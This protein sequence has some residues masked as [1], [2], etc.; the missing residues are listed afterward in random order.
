MNEHERARTLAMIEG[1]ISGDFEQ[2]LEADPG[3]DDYTCIAAKLNELASSL[4][5]RR[6]HPG[7]AAESSEIGYREIFDSATDMIFVQDAATGEFIDVN[8]ETV[9]ATGYTLAEFQQHGVQLFSPQSVE[10]S[11]DVAM[12]HIGKA[13][14][15]VPQLFEWAYVD[16]SG[17]IHPTEVHLKRMLFDGRAC[18]L[19]ITR[20]IT[21]R[22]KRESERLELDKK[23]LQGQKLESL[24]LLAGG[25]AHDFNN[26]LMGIMGHAG[27]AL[28]QLPEDTDA[29]A[30]VEKLETAADRATELMRQL[31]LFSGGGPVELVPVDLSELVEEITKLL[32]TVVSKRA[33]LTFDLD[34]ALPRVKGNPTA[35]RQIA[36]N[37]LTNASEA[38]GGDVGTIALKTGVTELGAEDLANTYVDWERPA[39][40]YSFLE[41]ADTGCGM[42]A[43]TISRLFDPFYSNK[44]FGRGL[45]LASVLGIVR[46]MKG[47]IDVQSA[48]GSGTRFTVFFPC[49]E[50]QPTASP[51]LTGEDATCTI[52]G[53]VL[54]VDDDEIA[55]DTSRAYL[56]ALGINS[57]TANSGEEGLQQLE[58]QGDSVKAVLLD[59]TMPGLSGLETLAEMRTNDWRQPVI[60]CS[61]YMLDE[62]ADFEIPRPDAY[63][64][65]PYTL[66]QLTKIL[67]EVLE[68][69]LDAIRS[70]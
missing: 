18:L 37:L 21:E 52:S 11:M 38:L 2:K 15:G 28:R 4:A 16:R 58:E 50:S 63:L 27:L 42:D 9:R 47:A 30:H 13:M 25:I 56:K 17:T 6:R 61:G 67:G 51:Q 20:D 33:Q 60:L 35:L 55:R 57:V 26:I 66:R 8:K 22:K 40:R 46:I 5:T 1:L 31:L 62:G 45:G 64:S 29:R 19:G 54:V 69:D 32:S 68:S 41:V 59:M 49:C 36:M 44:S 48:P 3:D 65:K 24:G 43:G 39:G 34:K 7:E 10:Y 70:R 14:E 23:I 53:C 12:G